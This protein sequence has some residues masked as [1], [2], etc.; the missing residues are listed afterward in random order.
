LFVC[1]VSSCRADH[2]GVYTFL[3]MLDDVELAAL[4]IENSNFK[5]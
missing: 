4:S 2:A 1:C 5:Y 3:L